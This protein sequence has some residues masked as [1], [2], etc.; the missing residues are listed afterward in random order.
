MPFLNLRLG[1]PIGPRCVY[2]DTIAENRLGVMPN[3]KDPFS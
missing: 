1:E 2:V 3:P